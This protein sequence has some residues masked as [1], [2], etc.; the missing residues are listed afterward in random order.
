M[1]SEFAISCR[2]AGKAFQLYLHRNDQLMQALF[3][4]AKTYYK[5]H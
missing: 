3:G 5:K 4:W 2:N 1:S